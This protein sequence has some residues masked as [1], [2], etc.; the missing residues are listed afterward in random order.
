M[1]DFNESAAVSNTSGFVGSQAEPLT[2]AGSQQLLK[3]APSPNFLFCHHPARWQIMDGELLPVLHKLLKS[4][5]LDNVGSKNGGDLGPAI[6]TKIQQ[7]WTIIPHDVIDGGYVAKF[8]GQRGDIHLSRWEQ[9]RQLGN[10]SFDPETD[11]VGYYAFLRGLVARGIVQPPDGVILEE[12]VDRCRQDVDRAAHRTET[13]AGR[14]V[15]AR[16][17]KTLEAVEI[18]CG[19]REALPPVKPTPKAKAKRAPRKPK[20]KPAEQVEAIDG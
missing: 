2:G 4:P 8:K 14:T 7:G 6:G 5:G 20:A 12:I 17:V 10:R 16:A 3:M 13:E 9:P 18:A 11:T 1:K 19:F 15:Y